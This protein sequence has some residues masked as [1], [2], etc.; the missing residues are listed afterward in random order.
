MDAADA[1][2]SCR[3]ELPCRRGRRCLRP[4]PHPFRSLHHWHGRPA[5]SNR[6][7]SGWT[8]RFLDCP[9]LGSLSS[10]GGDSPAWQPSNTMDAESPCREL[11]FVPT[12]QTDPRQGQRE[13][14]FLRRARTMTDRNDPTRANRNHVPRTNRAATTRW[15]RRGL[16]FERTLRHA[17]DS[18]G[19]SGV[20][21]CGLR[22]SPVT[23]TCRVRIKPSSDLHD[24]TSDGGDVDDRR[25]G[26]HE[27]NPSPAREPLARVSRWCHAL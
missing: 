22:A 10:C 18:A 5:T 20:P 21:P 6:G 9:E 11:Q 19:C 23:R 7:C 1:G 13:G 3:L 17:D 15:S 4:W 24:E 26:L 2:V 16:R 14:V 8:G 27:V 12:R 25:C